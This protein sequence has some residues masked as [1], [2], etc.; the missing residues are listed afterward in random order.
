MADETVFTPDVEFVRSLKEAGAETMKKCYQC[1]TCSV[2]CELSTEKSP[3]PR[4]EMLM[5]QWG[6]K[7]ELVKDPNIWLCHNCNDC[8]KYCP[9]GARP[10]DV[11]GVLRQTVI[12][13][14]AFPKFMGRIGSDHNYLVF[15][16][17][18]PIMLFLVILGAFGHLHIP[19]GPVV[20]DHFFPV[21]LID[22]IFISAAIISLLFFTVSIKNFW[23]GM[24]VN[25]YRLMAN[26]RVIPYLYETLKEMILH[27]KFD[28]CG[29]NKDRTLAHRLVVF[30]FIG[31]F[32]TTNVAVF[33][34]YVLG[35]H[36]PY[37]IDDPHILKLFGS[38]ALVGLYYAG[39]KLVGNLSALALLAG[40]II[41]FTNRTK[42][43]GFV[44]VSSP[45][46]WVFAIV[47]LLL[48][49]T[50]ILA[51]FLRVVDIAALAY[52][53]YFLHLVFVFFIIAY[54][55]YS[56]LAHIVYRTT[57]ITYAKLAKVE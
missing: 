54:L 9:R 6:L 48:A 45:F 25:P 50:G 24:N 37:H 14:N 36:T 41:I 27:T 2:V 47:I 5:A 51:E 31:L 38:E 49:I 34:M 23:D 8:T 30:G 7:E 56:K 32:I 43:K 21:H 55:P 18:L 52:P 15:A 19:D 42:P 12:M 33:N 35:W 11:L 26:G 16:F 4:R 39:F 3:F 29:A 1:A 53:V 20:F 40:A 22:P 13:E 28:K 17:G 44:S 46:D 57:A 10:G